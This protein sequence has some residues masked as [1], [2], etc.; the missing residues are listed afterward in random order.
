MVE[1]DD[2]PLTAK[3]KLRFVEGKVP[4][5]P[6]AYATEAKMLWDDLKERYSQGNKTMTYQLKSDICLY[7]QGRMTIRKYYSGIKTL[8][9]E[10]ENYLE[11]PGCSCEAATRYAAQRKKDK[12]RPFA[13]TEQDILDGLGGRKSTCSLPFSGGNTHTK[14][15]VELGAFAV[16]TTS[17]NRQ[18]QCCTAEGKPICDHCGRSGY[19]KGSCRM[20]HGPPAKG[21]NKSKG[22]KATSGQGKQGAHGQWRSSGQVVAQQWRGSGQV[23]A[24]MDLHRENGVEVERLEVRSLEMYTKEQDQVARETPFWDCRV[25]SW[26]H[27]LA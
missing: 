14:G 6:R 25:P 20:L 19:I 27:Y 2:D 3:G 24:R 26:R 7:R 16:K 10:L 15:R 18:G 12:D 8:W 17:E 11:S 22:K 9:D 1:G 21:N 5:P 4:R 13:N 23:Q